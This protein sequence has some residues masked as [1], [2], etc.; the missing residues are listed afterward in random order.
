MTLLARV[1]VVVA[2]SLL[3]A[4]ASFAA[5]YE[6]LVDMENVSGQDKADWPV[7]L[8]VYH[9]F[10]RNLPPGSLNPKGF[11]VYDEAGREMPCGVEVIPPDD[12]V[13]NDELVFVIP[14]MTA[15]QKLRY[16]IANTP[17]PSPRQ[18]TIDVVGNANNLLRNGGFE[19]ADGTAVAGY[20]GEAVLDSQVRRGGRSSMRI[21]APSRRSVRYKEPIPLHRGSWYYAGVWGKTRNVA[22]H[23]VHA[24]NGA[25][26]VITGFEGLTITPLCYTRDWLKCRFFARYGIGYTDWGMDRG[27][28]QATADACELTLVLDQRKNFCMDDAQGFWWLDDAVLIEQP[29]LDVRFDLALEKHVKDGVFLF[30]RPTSSPHFQGLK[31]KPFF[32]SRPYAHE[33]VE[34]L[35]RVAVRGQRAVFLLG[36]YHTRALEQVKVEVEGGA[37]KLGEAGLKLDSLEYSPGLLDPESNP[38]LVDHAGP[39]DLPASGVRYFLA[40]FRV[41]RDAAAG[42]YAGTLAVTIGGQVAKRIPLSLRVQDLAQPVLRDVAIGTIVMDPPLGPETLKLYSRA[43]FS[44]ITVFGGFLKYNKAA[45]G[46]Q[47]I[48]LDHFAQR[49][50]ELAAHGITAGVNL[51]SEFDLGPLWGGG[52]LYKRT[53]GD[54]QAWQRELKRID[55]LANKRPDWPR[56]IYMTWDEPVENEPWVK[57]K[58]GGLDDR[59]GWANEVNPNAL[60]TADVMFPLL[61]KVFKYYTMPT[62]D[63]PCDYGGPEVYEY[64]RR[65]NKPFGMSGNAW[66]GERSRYNYGMLPAASGARYIHSYHAGYGFIQLSPDKKVRPTIWLAAAGQ[67]MDDYKAWRLLNDSLKAAEGDAARAAAVAEAKAYLERIRTVWNGDHGQVSGPEP[68]MGRAYHW[69]YE[70][71]YDDWQEAMLKLSAKLR[72]VKWVE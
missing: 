5:G 21:A 44:S 30:T 61:P 42:R 45:D 13:G 46:Q 33:A 9:V 69:G 23:G 38:Q 12:Q 36:L 28:A 22:R 34:A 10:G 41:P 11:H 59:M 64:F 35:D 67:G 51:F 3:A 48:D 20:E 15:G 60:S 57:G 72:G 62:F 47:S 63:D 27:H 65:N 29:K 40:A 43:G 71:F 50:D 19:A 31:G 16:R 17:E 68:Y 49:M 58:H 2:V 32:C 52:S 26:F 56:M 1:A 66:G 53:G 4:Q 70:R 55:D 8:T 39:I 18:G 54:K 24:G 7:V 37:V 14:K 6:A 25:G